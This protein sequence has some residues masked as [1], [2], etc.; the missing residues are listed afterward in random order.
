MFSILLLSITVNAG[1]LR[2]RERHIDFPAVP[3]GPVV[4]KT[5]VAEYLQ[6]IPP[7]TKF[8][9]SLTNF[10]NTQY[11]GDII[12]G[13][14]TLHGIFDT[15]SFEL[16]VLSSRC[17][18]CQR[19]G[20]NHSSSTTYVEPQ[21][22]TAKEFHFGSGPALTVTGYENVRVGPYTVPKMPIWE[23]VDHNIPVLEISKL[24]AIVG[25]GP[26]EA[27]RTTPSLMQMMG[28]TRYSVCLLP[29]D[30]APGY[31]IWQDA[32]PRANPAFTPIP[33]EGEVHWGVRLDQVKVGSSAFACQGGC[34]AVLD[35]GT[36]LIAAPRSSLEELGKSLVNLS[37]DCSNMHEMPMLNFNLGGVPISLPPQ[38]YI[39]RMVG[40]IPPS[41]WDILTFRPESEV[42]MQCV[43]LLMD[44]D[45]MTTPM[46]PLWI[47]GMPFFRFYYTTFDIP[48]RE[49]HIAHASSDCEPIAYPVPINQINATDGAG[50]SMLKQ[51]EKSMEPI[52]INPA[53]L[54]AP[55]LAALKE[56]MDG[57]F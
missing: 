48:T 20:Y 53:T 1:L 40:V 13:G 3:N 18:S 2:S 6:N 14:Q 46:G 32:D 33:V 17:Q 9:Q 38:A 11:Y 49:V 56:K 8:K 7:A 52:T 36:S 19:Y 16:L 45:T 23:I 54:T 27:D 15:G 37:P 25:I 51:H 50:V 39:A 43:P 41:V 44:L 22:Q 10:Q 26:G 4:R 24:D 29:Q 30:Q 57:K 42:V 21:D 31:M 5:N 55:N 12:V 28:I 34:G 35:S 47:I